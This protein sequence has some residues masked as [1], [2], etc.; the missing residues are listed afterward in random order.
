M[1]KLMNL[2]LRRSIFFP[3]AEIYSNTP[4][5]FYDYGPIGLKI[6]NNIVNFW[7]KHLVEEL[8]AIE[9]D[10]AIAL[11]E[12]VFKSS[13]HLEGFFDPVVSCSKCKSAFRV[14]QMLEKVGEEVGEKTDLETLDKLVEKHGLV[15]ERCKSKFNKATRFIMMFKTYAGVGEGMPIYLRPEACQNIFL[16]FS[17][18][19]KGFGAKLPM[20][21]AQYGKAYRNEISP[22][23]AWIR[24]REFT[25]MDIEIFLAPDEIDNYDIKDMMEVKI[26]VKLL[27]SNKENEFKSIKELIKLKKLNFGVETYHLVKTYEFFVK[28]GF[29][30][31]LL[32]YKEVS[33]ED[34][35]FYSLATWDFEA[36]IDELGWIELV[37]NNYRTNHDLGGHM[38][39]SG[40]NLEVMH[41]DKKVLPYIMEISMGVDRILYCLMAQNIEDINEKL[42]LKL[43]PEITPYDASIFPLLKKDGLPE[44]AKVILKELKDCFY[45]IL[46]DEKGSI[47]KR[48]AKYDEL[49]IRY[50]I[51]VDHD[52][53]EKGEVT[54]RDAW[55]TK[56]E[57]VKV[58]NLKTKL[59]ELK[60]KR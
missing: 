23:N 34:R 19:Y 22:R 41:N 14:D 18:I 32:R 9:I 58:E 20:S 54:I 30:P 10:G 13:G 24:V 45:N 37:A 15:C 57:K 53:L 3:T 46:Y 1:Q 60:F 35:P 38:K 8:S 17:R 48:Y 56:Q 43:N 33:K 55:T 4:A 50:A 29:N 5:G 2:A 25:Q 28:M 12:S 36:K 26:P 31:E 47:G 44:K 59:F 40:T 6:R 11:P 51:T 16:D 27:E 39:G 42:V 21:I 49:G 7:R 52:T